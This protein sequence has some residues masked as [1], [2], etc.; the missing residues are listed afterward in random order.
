MFTP[1]ITWGKIRTHF[2]YSVIVFNRFSIG[3]KLNHQLQTLKRKLPNLF[4]HLD[5]P[6]S[7]LQVSPRPSN[8]P[9]LSC[10]CLSGKFT[11]NVESSLVHC[12]FM[13]LNMA[14]VHTYTIVITYL[15]A[16]YVSIFYLIYIYVY[17]SMPMF[18]DVL[19]HVSIYTY[20]YIYVFVSNSN[21]DISTSLS[22]SVNPYL[23]FYL[24]LSLCTDSSHSSLWIRR[25]TTPC[26]TAALTQGCSR[27]TPNASASQCLRTHWVQVSRSCCGK[28][29]RRGVFWFVFCQMAR[30]F[31]WVHIETVHLD[32][33]WNTS[34]HDCT[35]IVSSIRIFRFW[36]LWCF[37]WYW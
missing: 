14:H 18:R 32:L 10:S 20:I 24:D 21:S 6:Q 17:T 34:K 25:N 19:H 4:F 9:S 29:G 1:N 7:S 3:L 5:R 35:G 22:I 8:F 12:L 30:E 15:Q 11:M 26:P 13:F 31:G 16:I 33:S 28:R 37:K 2:D 23:Y 36:N 27:R